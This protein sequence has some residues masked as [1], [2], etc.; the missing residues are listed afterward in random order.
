MIEVF[1]TFGWTLLF[2][3]LAVTVVFITT[4]DRKQ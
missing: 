1:E 4:L 3:G 2:G